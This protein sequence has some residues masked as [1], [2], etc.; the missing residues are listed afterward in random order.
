MLGWIHG[1]ID[2]SVARASRP[3]GLLYADGFGAGL[4]A[5]VAGVRDYVGP[6]PVVEVEWGRPR[7]LSGLRV[8]TGRFPSPAARYLPPESRTGI[9][10][11]WRPS[12]SAPLCLVLAATGEEG[13]GRR[14][15]LAVYLAAHGVGS[16]LL[17][18]PYY[19]VRRPR[20]QRGP[21]LRTVADQFAMNL[22]TT[23][24]AA[25]LL[26]TF[27][28][29]GRLVGVTGYS[30]GG[31]M[32]AFGAA[33]SDF[34][35]VVVP[36]G[37]ARAAGPVFTDSAL[38]R[39]M[40]WGALA[41]EAGSLE[42]ARRRFLEALEPVRVDRFPPPREPRLAILVSS[43]DDGYV[44]PAEAEALHRHWAGSELRWVG[45]GHLTGVL[46]HH[47]EHRRAILDAFERARGGRGT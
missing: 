19:G 21:L 28:E 47:R 43:R 23:E 34:P 3:L 22:A 37:A 12:G 11:E 14:R 44:P 10:E 16:L 36:R 46:L 17:E 39:A 6:A 1:E 35:V 2:R 41:A 8:R 18:N 5:R 15:G 13:L 32:A 33:V 20:G 25:S 4:D 40:D 24:E 27:H 31:M 9:V 29:E 42:A 38:S 30:Q 26:R 45:G 7:E